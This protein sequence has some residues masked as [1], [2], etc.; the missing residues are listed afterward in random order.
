MS[1]LL[2]RSTPVPVFKE[3]TGAKYSFMTEYVEILMNMFWKFDAVPLGKDVEHYKIAK[4]SEGTK[5]DKDIEE[6]MKLFTQNEV[7]YSLLLV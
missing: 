6:I 1:N 5:E 3:A 7:N 4:A 2:N